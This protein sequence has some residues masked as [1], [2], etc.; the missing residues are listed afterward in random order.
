M[1]PIQRWSLPTLV[2]EISLEGVPELTEQDTQVHTS[3][4][5]RAHSPAHRAL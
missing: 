2:S 4:L 3:A 1:R 5:T